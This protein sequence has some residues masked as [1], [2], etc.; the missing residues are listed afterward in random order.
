MIPATVKQQSTVNYIRHLDTFFEIVRCCDAIHYANI[1]MYISLFRLWNLSYFSN[2]FSPTRED[3]MMY[4]GFRSKDAFYR[5][6][7]ELEIL[8]L[9]RYYP[10]RSRFERSFFCMSNLEFNDQVIKVEVWGLTNHN[11]L[12]QSKQTALNINQSFDAP[13]KKAKDLY[14]KVRAIN[15]KGSLYIEKTVTFELKES[16]L[17]PSPT[18]YNPL[19]DPKYASQ[20]DNRISSHNNNSNYANA[21]NSQSGHSTLRPSGVP[22]DPEADYSIKL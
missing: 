14:S 9:I 10:S 16:G 3:I 13:E 11:S 4:S 15:G 6:L 17:N 5:N 19:T 21:K 20:I 18:T 7:R 1:A 12:D 8:D 22:V 2:P